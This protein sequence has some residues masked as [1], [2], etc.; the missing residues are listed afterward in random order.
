MF[1]TKLN[2]FFYFDFEVY[3]NYL[4]LKPNFLLNVPF[5]LHIF[6]NQVQQFYQILERVC[7]R[8]VDSKSPDI[9]IPCPVIA[10]RGFNSSNLMTDS[11][12]AFQSVVK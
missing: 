9:G 11:L 2:N 8:L 10:T 3:F 1:F 12:A 4:I 6:R 5:Y 7:W